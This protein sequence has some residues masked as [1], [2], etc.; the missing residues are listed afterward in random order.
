MQGHPGGDAHTRYLIELSFLPPGSRWLDM[1]AGD[2]QALAILEEK[3]FS[4]VGIDLSP[5]S[6]RVERGD[7]L[8]APYET[9]SFDG[10]LSQCSFYVSGNVP[11]ALTEAARLLRKEGKLVFSDVTEDV[12]VLLNQVRAA[13]F[14]VRH[15]E[16]LTDQWKQHYLEA[17]W[18]EEVPCPP[19]KGTISYVLF[20]CERM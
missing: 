12:V 3:G 5:R 14:A 9:G 11:L 19:V 17:L 15:L 4:A 10:A 16:D 6:L 8:R 13:G 20:V 7:F 18:R 1:G 2:G